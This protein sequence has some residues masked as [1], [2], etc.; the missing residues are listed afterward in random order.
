MKFTKLETRLTG[1]KSC[2]DR[3][4]QEDAYTVSFI[5]PKDDKESNPNLECIYIGVFDGHGGQ[6]ASKFAK[7]HLELNITSNRLFWSDRDK[8]VL[9]AIREGNFFVVCCC[10]CLCLYTYDMFVMASNA[11]TCTCVYI[12]TWDTSNVEET[13]NWPTFLVTM[14]NFS[15]SSRFLANTQRHVEGPGELATYS[16][17]ILLNC[18]HHCLCSFH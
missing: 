10:C 6:E 17:G 14:R 2:G 1:C 13:T 5:Q 16:C 11:C 7:E 15:F 9:K 12:C 4:Y 3:C 18:W 8:D